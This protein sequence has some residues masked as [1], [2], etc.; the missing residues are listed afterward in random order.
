MTGVLNFNQAQA[1]RCANCYGFITWALIE[2]GYFQD[3]DA[4]NAAN[5]AGKNKLISQGWTDVTAEVLQSESNL[6][7]GDI[8][9]WKNGSGEVHGEIYAGNGMVLSCGFSGAFGTK[10][11]LSNKYHPERTYAWVGRPPE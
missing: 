7:P 10:V 9:S 11:L 4:I 8:I 1:W 6:K 3:G 2:C 5:N